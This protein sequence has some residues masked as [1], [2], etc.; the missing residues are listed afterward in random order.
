MDPMRKA[1]EKL[2]SSPP[3]E[4]STERYDK[5]SWWTAW[6][7]RYKDYKVHLAWDMFKAGVK[8]GKE[9]STDGRDA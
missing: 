6:P 9:G 1:F 2:I 3:Y 5:D 8:Y 7:G 4:R